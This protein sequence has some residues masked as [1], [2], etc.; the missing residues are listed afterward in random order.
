MAYFINEVGNLNYVRS[1]YNLSKTH[2]GHEE[3]HL[4]EFEQIANTII[5]KKLSD[6][7]QELQNKTQEMINETIEKSILSYLKGIKYDCEVC[8]QVLLDT[9]QT[10]LNKR[11][12]TQVISDNIFNQMKQQL[13]KTITIK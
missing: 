13:N 6:F 11:E 5:D 1:G 8:A 3:L 9:G 7:S 10:I 12:L 4:N 2:G